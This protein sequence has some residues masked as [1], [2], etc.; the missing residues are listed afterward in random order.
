[1]AMLPDHFAHPMNST[2]HLHPERFFPAETRTRDIAAR[3]FRGVEHL[4]IVSPHGHTDPG[5]FAGNARSYLAEL[6][7]THR[8]DEDEAAELAVELAYRLPK[9]AYRL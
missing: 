4:S 6:V 3:L 2:L 9:A 7:A 5:W 8:L 1:M